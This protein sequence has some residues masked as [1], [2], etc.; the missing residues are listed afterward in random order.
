MLSIE[1]CIAL[2]GEYRVLCKGQEVK[3]GKKCE[4]KDFVKDMVNKYGFMLSDL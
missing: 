3:R 4:C 2:K 1:K